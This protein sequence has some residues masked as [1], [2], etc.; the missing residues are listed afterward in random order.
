M[1]VSMDE[2]IIDDLLDGVTVV[3]G[4]P[5]MDKSTLY[6]FCIDM[7]QR[8]HGYDTIARRYGFV[9]ENM[10][11]EFLRTHAPVVKRVKELR[12]VWESDESVELRLRKLAGHSLLEALPDTASIMF[13]RQVTP[14]VRLEALRAH[15][16]IAG[17]DSPPTQSSSNNATGGPGARFSVQ[18]VFNN[19]G[20]V[21]TITAS[22]RHVKEIEA[23]TE[24]TREMDA[25]E[26]F[27]TIMDD[28][29]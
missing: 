26:S 11:V 7:A 23:E 16:R 17:V 6:A 10:L 5:E 15:A 27:D 3:G 8:I 21:E 18:I 28:A 1:G 20:K 14:G 2:E 19:A 24:M 12:A 4:D 25:E 9:D 29:P 22:E 13:D